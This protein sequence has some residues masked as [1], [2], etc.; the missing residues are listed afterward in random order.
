MKQIFVVAAIIENKG[1]ILCTQRGKDKHDYT[2][3]KWEFPG[4][5]IEQGESPQDALKRE[6][7]EEL[8]MDINIQS[9]FCDIKYKYP[10][11]TLNMSCY[12]CNVDNLQFELNVHN[13]FLWLQKDKLQTLD[14]VPADKIIVQKLLEQ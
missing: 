6:L 4:G 10:D 3:Y 13:D 11:F 5:K 12:L 2:S 8:N 9:H 14:W 1:K 7:I